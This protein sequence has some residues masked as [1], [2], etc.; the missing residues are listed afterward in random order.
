MCSI[1]HRIAVTSHS[2]QTISGQIIYLRKTSIEWKFSVTR[3]HVITLSNLNINFKI[4]LRAYPGAGERK[5]V[6]LARCSPSWWRT[7]RCWWRPVAD[8]RAAP[9]TTARS[10]TSTA[11]RRRSACACRRRSDRYSRR[12]RRESR[13]ETVMRG[14]VNKFASIDIWTEHT[15]TG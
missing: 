9:A 12:T 8:S 6:Q 13:R 1:Q 14:L 4:R 7:R 11:W 5:S 2:N 3:H 10:L 15:A